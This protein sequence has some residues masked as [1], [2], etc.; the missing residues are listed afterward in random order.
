M[1][2]AAEGAMQKAPP[3]EE[4]GQYFILNPEDAVEIAPPE[5]GGAA[6]RRR[7]GR[8]G[9]KDARKVR[10]PRFS[11]AEWERVDR[12][13]LKVRSTLAGIGRPRMMTAHEFV[14]TVVM[15]TVELLEEV[16]KGD[17]PFN[18]KDVLVCGIAPVPAGKRTAQSAASARNTPVWEGAKLTNAG[19]GL[20]ME[21]E[22]LQKPSGETPPALIP[23]M[24]REHR[25]RDMRDCPVEIAVRGPQPQGRRR[26]PK[27]S[28]VCVICD[29]PHALPPDWPFDDGGAKLDDDQRAR[30]EAHKKA[31]L[32]EAAK[33]SEMGSSAKPS[34]KGKR[35]PACGL[36]EDSGRHLIDNDV[37]RCRTQGLVCGLCD[38]QG[39]YSAGPSLSPCTCAAGRNIVAK[40][41]RHVKRLR[42]ELRKAKKA[43]RAG[44]KAPPATA[45]PARL[46]L[47]DEGF[48]K[49]AEN[50][51]YICDKEI[52]RKESSLL[53]DIV[54]SAHLTCWRSLPPE[55]E[56]KRERIRAEALAADRAERTE[57]A[58]PAGTAKATRKQRSKKPAAAV[59]PPPGSSDEFYTPSRH[60]LPLHEEFG[61]TLDVCATAESAKCE[62]YFT[63]EQDGLKQS[64]EG[65]V[66]FCNPPF[67][68]GNLAAFVAK[69]AEEARKPGH[70]LGVS[71]LPVRTDRK[72]WQE[73]IEPGRLDGSLEVR[74]NKGRIAFGY[75]G[76]PEGLGGDTGK[77]PCAFV[78]WRPKA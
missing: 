21:W 49:G 58:A 16:P 29:W 43:E 26:P 70:R 20:E 67:S 66:W 24:I 47:K 38:D 56:E 7:G 64:W 41:P 25:A 68:P 74:F 35:P 48:T 61:F 75:P 5:R 27:Y 77:D 28:K 10:A 9:S 50:V 37:C 63:K 13:M 22:Q 32:A 6:L 17:R 42:E 23:A 59:G 31:V 60:Y 18:I 15:R 55:L 40:G 44:L 57:R 73:H 12:E 72:W 39:F 65:E 71:V 34:R 14:W 45:Q 52:G 78:I 19:L 36:C 4:D 30:L 53:H 62:R 3:V 54:G 2:A 1:S 46:T 8:A 11:D 33:S 76:N 69:C 51:C